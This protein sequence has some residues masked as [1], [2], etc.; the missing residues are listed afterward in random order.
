MYIAHVLTHLHKDGGHT[1]TH[2]YIY[3]HTSKH[4]LL[5]T[6]FCIRNMFA[7]HFASDKKRREVL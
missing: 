1:H 2:T 4:I 3:M 5:H 6:A 7:M